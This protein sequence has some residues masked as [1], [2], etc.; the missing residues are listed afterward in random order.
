MSLSQDIE[1]RVNILDIVGRYVDVK[2][3]GVNYKALCPF[4]NEK[5]P[6]FI[7]S[8]QKN[9]AHCFSC[10][11][12]GGP[13][14]FLMEMEKIEFREAIQVLAK[15]A[16]VELKVDFQ[17]EKAEA[18]GDIYAL[19]RI[20][21]QWYHESLYKEENKRYLQ[22]LQERKISDATIK[23]FQ[24]GCSTS[25]RD[26]WYYLKEKGF[27]PQ[28]LIDSGIFI[29]EGRD[30]FFGRITYPIANSMGHV[31][32]F[33]GRV[34]DSALPK[35]LNSPASK[36]FDKSSTLYGLHLAKQA[37]SKTGEAYVVEGQ[38]DTIS[39]HQAGIENA[40]GISGT[41]L[42]KEHIHILKRFAKTIYLCL[43]SDDAG[44]KA[45]FLSIESL[46]NED[47]EV[48]I[49][50]IPNGKDPDEFIKSGGIFGDLRGS[51]L[52]PIGFYLKEGGREVDLTTIIGKKKLIEKCLIF[53]LSLK[54]QI[55]IDMH[56]NEI[57]SSLGVSKDAIQIEYKKGNF[58]RDT[59]SYYK[60]ISQNEELQKESFTP[61]ELLAGYIFRYS[62]F[63]LFSQEFQYT[64]ADFPHE[65]I[66]SLLS[67]VIN[68]ENLDPE[69]EER[70]KILSLHLESI[71]PDEDMSQIRKVFL[72]LLKHLHIELLVLEKKRAI[73]TG[74]Y[75]FEHHNQL[76][77]KALSFGLSPSVIGKY[78]Q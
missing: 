42:T 17:K 11:K 68:Q 55:E 9:I 57:A 78:N 48:R 8:P 19:Y 30:K 36:I 39:L 18:G 54:S 1:S 58:A 47:I 45:T 7:I 76:I 51:A 77:Q 60:K 16:G 12:G 75:T 52:S 5:S 37:I 3:A 73:E 41:A 2:K 56:M 44:V 72:D 23:K 50:E 53:L 71:H 6:S 70:L 10:G 35:Y 69:E 29:S 26:L 74:C 27:S 64:L 43:D 65:G 59:K 40:V 21:A 67:H 63:S 31:V 14:K 4:H 38:M 24:L 15:E 34:L 62:L 61:T 46:A 66:F 13:I 25:P 33:T 49:M 20:T 22:Y 28:F 32:A